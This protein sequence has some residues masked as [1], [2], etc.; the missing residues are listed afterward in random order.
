MEP[1]MAKVVAFRW[2]I[3]SMFVFAFY[4]LKRKS[5]SHVADKLASLAFIKHDY[6]DLTERSRTK[7]TIKSNPKLK[8]LI[9]KLE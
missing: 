9:L 1:S 4:G 6:I 7:G 5:H 8:P 3:E 2:T